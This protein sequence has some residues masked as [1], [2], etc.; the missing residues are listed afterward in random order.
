MVKFLKGL[1]MMQT[2]DFHVA[3]EKP[4]VPLSH[5]CPTEHFHYTLYKTQPA[6]IQ[7]EIIFLH[8]EAFFNV[9]KLL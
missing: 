2:Y 7:F 6:V 9:F 5:Q 4:T 1:A 8:V 3:N